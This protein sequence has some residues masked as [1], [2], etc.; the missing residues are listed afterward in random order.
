MALNGFA[1]KVTPAHKVRSL[2]KMSSI[3]EIREWLVK[4]GRGSVSCHI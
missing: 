4:T 1:Q 3:D 2:H